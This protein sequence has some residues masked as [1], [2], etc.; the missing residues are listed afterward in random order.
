LFSLQGS[1][2]QWLL[3]FVVLIVSLAVRNPWCGH[4]CPMRTIERALQG[5]RE[6]IRGRVEAA[7]NE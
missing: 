1:T 7:R 3:L 2:L 4:W 5:L 6:L